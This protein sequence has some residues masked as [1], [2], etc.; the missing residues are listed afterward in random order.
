MVYV[1][2]AIQVKEGQLARLIRLL[3]KASS[4]VSAISRTDNQLSGKRAIT[5]MACN[6][7]SLL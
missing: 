2:A 1:I 4:L 6:P 3:S 7:K 5:G